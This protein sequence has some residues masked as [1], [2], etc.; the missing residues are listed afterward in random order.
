MRKTSTH[1]IPGLTGVR[2]AGVISKVEDDLRGAFSSLF[3]CK[4]DAFFMLLLYISVV[5]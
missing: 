5:K 2:I 4:N 3:L 1:S